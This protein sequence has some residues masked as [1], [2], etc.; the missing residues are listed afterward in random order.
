MCRSYR[1]YELRVSGHR[2]MVVDVGR[3]GGIS[4]GGYGV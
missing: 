3:G 2:S 1:L 4:L